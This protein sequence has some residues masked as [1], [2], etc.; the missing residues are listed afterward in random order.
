MVILQ[1]HQREE[2]NY[3]TYIHLKKKGDTNQ[4]AV[5]AFNIVFVDLIL[6]YFDTHYKQ[7]GENEFYYIWPAF[8]VNDIDSDFASIIYG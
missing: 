8:T 5:L 3:N 4:I 6:K 2:I 7:V 1:Y